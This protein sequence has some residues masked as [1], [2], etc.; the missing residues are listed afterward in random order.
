MEK[1][2]MGFGFGIVCISFFLCVCVGMQ[3]AWGVVA[4]LIPTGIGYFFADP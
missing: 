2:V 3:F 4:G 1:I